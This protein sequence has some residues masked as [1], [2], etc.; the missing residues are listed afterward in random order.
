MVHSLILATPRIQLHWPLLIGRIAE[1]KWMAGLD[2][3]N[4]DVLLREEYERGTGQAALM[5]PFPFFLCRVSVSWAFHVWVFGD[6]VL[7]LCRLMKEALHL[8]AFTGRY[9]PTLFWIVTVCAE[10]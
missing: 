6:R 7:L 4:G 5:R 10:K 2:A 9:W 1:S 8:R 3:G